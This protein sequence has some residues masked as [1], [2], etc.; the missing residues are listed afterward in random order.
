MATHG[1]TLEAVH[2]DSDPAIVLGKRLE[3]K[4]VR[5][6]V[7]AFGCSEILEEPQ[8]TLSSRRTPSAGRLLWDPGLSALAQ[9]IM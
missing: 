8:K 4:D 6:G 3:L 7:Q 5:D 1:C 2:G 9:C